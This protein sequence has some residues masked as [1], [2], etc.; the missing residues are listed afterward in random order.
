[1]IKSVINSNNLNLD[2]HWFFKNEE[3][4][5]EFFFD[6]FKMILKTFKKVARFHSMEDYTK[7]VRERA[8]QKEILEKDFSEAELF[9][10]EVKIVLNVVTIIEYNIKYQIVQ[11]TNF[12][13]TSLKEMKENEQVSL[14]I[15]LISS[16][17]SV[18]TDLKANLLPKKFSR[19]LR[20]QPLKDFDS[21]ETNF[22]IFEFQESLKSLEE[23]HRN[24]L[25]VF[26]E[27][28]FQ[29][30]RFS[31][32]FDRS[33]DLI[34]SEYENISFENK[35]IYSPLNDTIS[36]M[37]DYNL[38]D[39]FVIDDDIELK[40]NGFIF[41]IVNNREVDQE[42]S[43]LKTI[44]ETLCSDYDNATLPFSISATLNHKIVFEVIEQLSKIEKEEEEEDEDRNEEE[45]GDGDEDSDKDDGDEKVEEEERKPFIEVLEIKTFLK[46]IEQGISK[47]E[48]RTIS[49]SI[50]EE[51]ENKQIAKEAQQN[52]QQ[53]LLDLHSL[54]VII[55]FKD[56]SLKDIVV[57]HPKWFNK[58]KSKKKKNLFV[59]K[60]NIKKNERYS[61]QSSILEEK[62][63]EGIFEDILEK[64]EVQP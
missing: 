38:Q 46:E 30:E 44:K 32:G 57:P 5:K 52:L 26:V 56:P 27:K 21:F 17:H 39:L 63:I 60:K 35:S 10:K 53:I 31:K 16:P 50:T 20:N 55:Y 12:R 7:F 23:I 24:S 15:N 3:K 64:F 2:F 19:V 42:R 36:T 22:S 43:G 13:K 29:V 6:I 25:L 61:N 49:N 45:E 9:Q 58:V 1:V 41:N 37:K 48:K 4:Q 14:L 59:K 62:K 47:L 54:G 51:D 40:K 34:I 33:K 11:N 28:Y 8:S 18:F